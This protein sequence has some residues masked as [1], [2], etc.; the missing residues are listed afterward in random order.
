VDSVLDP[1]AAS[2]LQPFRARRPWWGRDLQTI[3]NALRGPFARPDDGIG[4]EVLLP[5]EDGTGDALV[6]HLH[7][8]STAAPARRA[9]RPLAVLVHGLAGSSESAYVWGSAAYLLARGFPVLRLNL[10]GAGVSRRHCRLQYHAGRSEDLRAALAILGRREPDVVR[11][12]FALVGYSLGGSLVLKLL[13]EA[14]EELGIRVA[15]AISAP[16]DLAAACARMHAPRN[17]LYAR[18]MLRSMKQEATAPGA[19]LSAA[20]RAAIEAAPTIF[21]FDDRFV[22]PRNGWRGAFDYYAAAMALRALP[23]VRVPTLLL[24]ALDDPWIPPDAYLR[25]P[26]RKNR[27]LRPVFTTGGGHVGFH[28]SGDRVPWHDRRVAGFFEEVLP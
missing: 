21:A 27:R 10:R 12:G 11:G 7:T 20:E 24:H 2:S 19:E 26:W 8:P 1:A 4:R 5:L 16:I 9:A 18:R 13:A 17:R 3:R 15:A 14:G 22:A 6:A 25:F 28:A 23:E